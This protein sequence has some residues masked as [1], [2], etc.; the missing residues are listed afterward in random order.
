MGIEWR[1]PEEI[2][3]KVR[4]GELLCGREVPRVDAIRQVRITEQTFHRWRKQYGSMGPD[5]L[6][7][8]QRLHKE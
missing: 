8:P 4:L 7:E 6:S 3:T 2:V 1:K 5:Q